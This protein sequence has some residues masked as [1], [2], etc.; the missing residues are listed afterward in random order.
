MRA[1]PWAAALTGTAAAVW[2]FLRD[3][4]ACP[5]GRGKRDPIYGD[6]PLTPA[7][8]EAVDGAIDRAV[9]TKVPRPEGGGQRMRAALTRALLESYALECSIVVPAALER[10]GTVIHTDQANP[11]QMKRS[12]KFPELSDPRRTVAPW[13][14]LVHQ[15]NLRSRAVGGVTNV[16]IAGQGEGRPSARRSHS[17]Q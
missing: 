12:Y 10:P 1:V 2:A 4:R 14:G 16:D 3:R 13:A 11:V 17:H 15:G 9:R 6:E 7:A 8:Q 5:H